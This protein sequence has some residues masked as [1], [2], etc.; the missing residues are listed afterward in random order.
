MANLLSQ[1]KPLIEWGVALRAMP[2]EKV[3]GDSHLVMEL[4]QRTLA[5]VVDGLGHGREATAAATAAISVLEANNSESLISMVKRCHEALLKSRGAVMTVASF[6]RAD[7]TLTWL[8]VGN[9]SGLLLR[10]DPKSAPSSQSS[11]LRA[12]VVGFQL[13]ML[14]PGVVALFPRDLLILATDGIRDD[15]E[16]SINAAAAPQQIADRVMDLHF[17]GHDDAAVLVMRYLGNSL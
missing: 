5:A 16:R 12:G 15:F 4:P 2:G 11:L 13:P 6:N 10:A 8:S 7:D 17:K 3:S 14:R 1:R 9:V